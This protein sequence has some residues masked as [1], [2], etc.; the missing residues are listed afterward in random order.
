MTLVKACLNGNRRRDEHPALPV[1]PA[2]LALEA[3]HSRMAGA[4]AVHVHPR[5]ADGSES[6]EPHTVRLALEAIRRSCPGLPVG[7]TTASWVEPDVERRVWLVERWDALPDFASVNLPE[8][9]V[10]ELAEALLGRGV[11][12]EAGL[13]DPADVD[14]LLSFGFADRCL[15]VLV[16]IDEEKDGSRGAALA[17]EVDAA[18]DRAG[19]DAPRLHH[20][21]G[22]ATWQVIERGLERGHDVRVGLEDTLT[23]PDGSPAHDN[24]DLVRAAV[25]IAER[26]GRTVEPAVLSL[27]RSLPSWSNGSSSTP[28]A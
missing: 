21:G 17:E 27:R 12:V 1:S 8:N 23:R 10:P 16:E 13:L 6:L 24:A 9:G 14:R 11:G 2:E 22:A 4:G 5:A 26:L 20:A 7:I 19:I 15:R 28:P 3:H 25:G 18:L